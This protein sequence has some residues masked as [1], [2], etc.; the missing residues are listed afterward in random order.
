MKHWKVGILK[1]TSKPMLGL[2]GLHVAFRGLPNVDVV[3]HVDSNPQNMERKLAAT[4]A[5]RH[6]T[7]LS[8]MLDEVHP[9]VLVICSRHPDDHFPAI[10][11]AAKRGIHV[12]CEKPMTVSL[13]EADQIIELANRHRIKIGMAHPA[14]YAL[15]FRTMKDMIHAGEIGTPLTAHGRGKCDHRGGGE[16]LIVLGTHILDLQTFIFGKPQSVWANVTQN[17]KPITPSSRIK[18][19]EPL[20]PVA[21]DSIFACFNFDND[22]RCTFESRRG[23][24][25]PQ[26]GHIHMGLTVTGTK[27]ALSLRFND[28]FEPVYKLRISHAPAPPEDYAAYVEVPLEETRTIADA[29]PL[30]HSLSG[31]SDI[32]REPFFLEANRFAAWDLLQSITEDGQPL[33]NPVNARLA[34]EM[35]YGIY[36][37]HLSGSIVRF[38]LTN[39]MHPLEP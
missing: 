36:T 33:S 18:T 7:S 19:V 2:H 21:G 28:G 9:D 13:N 11:A 29:L 3:S 31:Q 24:L 35:I 38:P 15:A 37:S 12:Y 20:G 14:R 34:M 25:D 5:M 6:D 32:P 16:D 10:E 22:V 17:G 23:L 1:D 27:G 26:S 30:D 8:Q 4:R 39:P